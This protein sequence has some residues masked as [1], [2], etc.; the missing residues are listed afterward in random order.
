MGFQGCSTIAFFVLG[1]F[2]HVSADTCLK[3]II[4]AEEGK[5][6]LFD[7]VVSVSFRRVFLIGP[8]EKLW[9]VP[10]TPPLYAN[11]V[12]F[13]FYFER[14]HAQDGTPRGS[15]CNFT[16]ATRSLTES[17]MLMDF[18]MDPLKNI[19]LAYCVLPDEVFA[20]LEK[21]DLNFSVSFSR[22]DGQ[23]DLR[24]TLPLCRIP[25][26]PRVFASLCCIIRDEARY[27]AEWIEYSRM[28]GV[29]HFFLYDHASQDTT[30]AVLRRYEE[31]GVV[32][33]H[34]WSFPGY[35]QREAHTHCTHRYG[36]LTTWL[37]L[38][39]VDEFLVPVRS[40]SVDLLLSYFEHDLVVLRFSAMMY[41][42]SGHEEMPPGLVI[43]N[44]IMRNLSTYWP[45]NPQHKVWFRPGGNYVYLPSIHA[46]DV[47]DDLARHLDVHEEDM[48][49]NHYR[50]KS[51]AD[52]K[53]DPLRG[54]M[55]L[56]EAAEVVDTRLRDRFLGRLKKR[57]N[58]SSSSSS[59]TEKDVEGNVTKCAFL[60]SSAPYSKISFPVASTILAQSKPYFDECPHLA[61]AMIR[62]FDNGLPVVDVTPGTGYYTTYMHRRGLKVTGIDE[63]DLSELLYT[64]LFVRGS[65]SRLDLLLDTLPRGNAFVAFLPP[66]VVE[67]LEGFA[68]SLRQ[69]CLGRIV[70]SVPQEISQQDLVKVLWMQDLVVNHFA[71]SWINSVTKTAVANTQKFMLHSRV[72]VGRCKTE[73]FRIVLDCAQSP[74]ALPTTC[75]T[76]TEEDM[77][78]SFTFPANGT[79]TFPNETIVLEW[80]FQWLRLEEIAKSDNT[81]ICVVVLLNEKELRRSCDRT[82][83]ISSDE[84]QF[85]SNK[86]EFVPMVFHANLTSC[87]LSV[88]HL[89][90]RK[91]SLNN[92]D[93]DAHSCSPTSTH[94]EPM[95]SK[96]ETFLNHIRVDL[97]WLK[98]IETAQISLVQGP[99]AVRYDLFGSPDMPRDVT[100]WVPGCAIHNANLSVRLTL[101]ESAGSRSWLEEN[102]QVCNQEQKSASRLPSNSH[103]NSVHDKSATMSMEMSRL[104]RMFCRQAEKSVVLLIPDWLRTI[105]P[106]KVGQVEED[107]TDPTPGTFS[108]LLQLSSTDKYLISQLHLKT[109]GEDGGGGGGEHAGKGRLTFLVL[110]R[111]CSV[112]SGRTDWLYARATGQFHLVPA[113]VMRRSACELR[114][115]FDLP[116]GELYGIQLV[117][118]WSDLPTSQTNVH[119]EEK[120]ITEEVLGYV[121]SQVWPCSLLS[122]CL[123]SQHSSCVKL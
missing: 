57:M 3:E 52:H 112:S 6:V 107:K 75:P 34:N 32:T 98:G 45:T 16:M 73:I 60:E 44:Y 4:H 100:L 22:K 38:M 35:P 63:E 43:E 46:V 102:Y 78:M 110:R 10:S 19:N 83:S 69:L 81:D 87:K 54:H 58:L 56:L 74:L 62:L 7:V 67:K 106:L 33:L 109:A 122:F 49:Y 48:Y 66:S 71:T 79:W 23:G 20:R 117:P 21:E 12:L 51:L 25:S 17:W 65:A 50:T 123:T 101:V 113:R 111:N 64:S 59:S 104:K 86:I 28:I 92:S 2:L 70:L 72:D 114:I 36:H 68:S 120:D 26:F 93:V 1:F 40:E 53:L 94:M 13:P 41:G 115:Q 97:S 18:I 76:P 121:G 90:I 116:A 80:M 103:Y 42:T 11:S 119:E 118:A 30:R 82:I 47:K 77:T 37:G 31:E 61:E 105:V 99:F 88:Y 85:G 39:D 96:I 5:V 14:G 89:Y 9:V 91:L 84:L 15:F 8:H 24:L 95:R 55:R 27:L 108:S 29:N